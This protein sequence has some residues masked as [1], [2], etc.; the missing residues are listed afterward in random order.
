ML[1]FKVLA[2]VGI[3]KVMDYIFEQKELFYLDDILPGSIKE[4][5]LKENE[6]I[7]LVNNVQL[8]LFF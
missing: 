1:E 5:P 6:K 8:D 2:L 4:Q 3:R 7:E